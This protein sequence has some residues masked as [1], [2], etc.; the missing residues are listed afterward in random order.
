MEVADLQATIGD[1]FLMG[2][3]IFKRGDL[4]LLD[5][6]GKKIDVSCDKCYSIA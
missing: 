3:Y 5:K 4:T 1:I 2:E 6:D